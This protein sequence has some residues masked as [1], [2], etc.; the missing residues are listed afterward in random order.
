M[1]WFSYEIPFLFSSQGY[2][3]LWCQKSYS[4]CYMVIVFSYKQSCGQATVLFF[5]F[6][7]HDISHTFFIFFKNMTLQDSDS[8]IEISLC[9]ELNEKIFNIP[10]RSMHQ[11]ILGTLLTVRWE[12][13]PGVTFEKIM[14]CLFRQPLLIRAIISIRLVNHSFFEYQAFLTYSKDLIIDDV[15]T[16]FPISF[17]FDSFFKLTFFLF[18]R[19]TIY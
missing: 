8:D 18:R 13:K 12:P 15:S 3:V 4:L 16:V 9:E 17:F 11:L 2:T 19:T 10:L 7:P 6:F 14:E 5:L 1:V